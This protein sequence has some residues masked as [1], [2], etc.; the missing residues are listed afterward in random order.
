MSKRQ[1]FH[2]YRADGTVDS[3]DYF[4]KEHNE[5]LKDNHLECADPLELLLLEEAYPEYINIDDMFKPYKP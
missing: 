5:Q 3:E 4:A 2:L 1:K